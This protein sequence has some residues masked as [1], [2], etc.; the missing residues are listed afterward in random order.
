MKEICEKNSYNYSDFSEQEKLITM[1]CVNMAAGLNDIIC[2][3]IVN[4]DGTINDDAVKV[5]SK[6]KEIQSASSESIEM[7]NY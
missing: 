3:E 2:T 5:I 7:L 1:T 4:E 6:A